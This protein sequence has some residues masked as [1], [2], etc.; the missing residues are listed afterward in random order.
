VGA[1]PGSGLYQFDYRLVS[2]VKYADEIVVIVLN[3]EVAR[4][5]YPKT[6]LENP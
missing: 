2:E 5:K 6:I 4:A 3:D 1:V